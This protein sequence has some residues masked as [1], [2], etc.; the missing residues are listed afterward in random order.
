MRVPPKVPFY[1]KLL[2]I[3]IRSAKDIRNVLRVVLLHKEASGKRLFRGSVRAKP[4]T[5]ENSHFQILF[6]KIRD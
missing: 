1:W 2:K 6:M 3:G 4:L 5:T